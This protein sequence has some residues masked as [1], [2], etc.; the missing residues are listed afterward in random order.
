[1]IGGVPQA[2]FN[3]G[4]GWLQFGELGLAVLLSGA[5]GIEREI[6]QKDAGLRTYTLVGIGSALFMLISKFGFSDVIAEGLVVVDP[7][8]VAA[9]IVTGVGFLGA[10]LIFVR[11]DGVKGLTTATAIWLTAAIGAAAGAGLPL[12]ATGTT[13]IYFLLAFFRPIL[14][15]WISSGQNLAYLEIS[16][17]QKGGSLVRVLQLVENA[18][19]TVM[20]ASIHDGPDPKIKEA[21]LVVSGKMS[22]SVLAAELSEIKN[23]EVISARGEMMD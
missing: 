13:A 20:N 3:P 14:R 12:L 16:F 15:R 4:E 19:S 17:P 18:G 6:R 8:R 5:I 2:F 11:K 10:G 9:Q 22:P 21:E 7:S 23:V 1:V